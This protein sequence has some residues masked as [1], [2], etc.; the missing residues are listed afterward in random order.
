MANNRYLAESDNYKVTSEDETVHLHFKNGDRKPVIIGDFWGDPECAMISR[1]E[2][3]VV[4]AGCGLIVYLLKEPFDE[5]QYGGKSEGT[6]VNNQFAEF[7]R[8]RPDIWW[9]DGLHQNRLDQDFSFFRF[10]LTENEGDVVY[11]MDTRTWTIER[12]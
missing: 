6:R 4:M 12:V 8:D 9:T 5:Y 7:H 1:D 10:V 11:R 3:Y 2:K